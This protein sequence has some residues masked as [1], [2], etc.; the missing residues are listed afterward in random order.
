M[1]GCDL[2]RRS[3]ILSWSHKNVLWYLFGVSMNFLCGDDTG[4]ESIC[5][6][7]RRNAGTRDIYSI[8]GVVSLSSALQ[9]RQC[10]HNINIDTT[11][12]LS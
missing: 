9:Q 1:W 12:K 10:N 11:M 4:S 8:Y 2:R 7:H 6:T 5:I 3:E